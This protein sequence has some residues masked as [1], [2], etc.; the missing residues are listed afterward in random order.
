MKKSVDKNEAKPGETVKYTYTV[1]NTGN[2]DLQVTLS[3]VFSKDGVKLDEQLVLKDAEGKIYKGEAFTLAYEGVATFTAE[4]TIPENTK[5]DTKFHNVVTATSGDLEVT[6]DATVTVAKDPGLAVDKSVDKKVAK[7]GETVIYTYT[8][9]NTGNS[10]LK[11]TLAD[12][13]SKNDKEMDKQLVIYDAK[14]QRL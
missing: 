2:S 9:T 6:D 8:V 11:V 10:D 3:D 14:R 4:F 12:V 13:F 1:T 5:V 7:P